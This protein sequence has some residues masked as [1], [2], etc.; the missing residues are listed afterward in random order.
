MEIDSIHASQLPEESKR[1]FK[2]WM[3]AEPGRLNQW[4]AGDW[5][6]RN[7]FDAL[8]EGHDQLIEEARREVAEAFDARQKVC[9]TESTQHS[10]ETQHGLFNSQ[11]TLTGNRCANHFKC[12]VLG[13]LSPICPAKMSDFPSYWA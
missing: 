8:P 5:F 12:L 10:V 1:A 9:V 2:E 7:G 13:F 3:K 6:R 11:L 4:R